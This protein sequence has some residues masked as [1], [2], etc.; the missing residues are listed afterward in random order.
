[1]TYPLLTYVAWPG[2]G[3]PEPPIQAGGPLNPRQGIDPR[4]D[5]LL[6]KDSATAVRET[7]MGRR[8]F[9]DGCE[10][11]E[12]TTGCLMRNTAVRSFLHIGALLT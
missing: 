11:D 6:A 9:R 12:V 5:R 10:V 7:L 1:M 4:D 3:I 2:L 8:L